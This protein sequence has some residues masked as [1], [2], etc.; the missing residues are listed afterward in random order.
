MYLNDTFCWGYVY[1]LKEHEWSRFKCRY[2]WRTLSSLESRCT[3]LYLYIVPWVT[4]ARLSVGKT[5]VA[6]SRGQC[7]PEVVYNRTSFGIPQFLYVIHSWLLLR[8][9][10]SGV[11]RY[12]GGVSINGI[13][14]IFCNFPF[15]KRMGLF[16]L[17]DGLDVFESFV[18]VTFTLS[19]ASVS[20]APTHHA[21]SFLNLPLHTA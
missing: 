18:M 4:T 17:R 13:S 15:S 11:T 19:T 5:G 6:R 21:L 9:S 3:V 20:Y 12:K 2:L 14:Y 10:S 8:K 16:Y 1:S 7:S